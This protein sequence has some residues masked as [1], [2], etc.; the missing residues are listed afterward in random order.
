MICTKYLFSKLW[1]KQQ[2]QQLLQ[3][4]G[5][6]FYTFD[7]WGLDPEESL[8][9]RFREDQDIARTYWEYNRGNHVVNVVL[10]SMLDP[11]KLALI[12]FVQAYRNESKF[13]G[14][15]DSEEAF[16]AGFVENWGVLDRA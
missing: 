13:R 16:F 14:H 7:Y 6:V 2:K 3:K 1:C 12:D 5:F 4:L 10:K 11:N 15:S 9:D 8:L